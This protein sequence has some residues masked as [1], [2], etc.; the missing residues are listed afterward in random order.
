MEARLVNSCPLA[1]T[2][3]NEGVRTFHNVTDVVR[4]ERYDDKLL[5]IRMNDETKSLQ[6]DF[7]VL[8]T[9]VRP[10]E[11]LRG[12]LTA[13]VSGLARDVSLLRP[14]APSNTAS[15]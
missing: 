14:N 11:H 6:L 7:T 3:K 9:Q 12:S 15:K 5:Q 4:V 13:D 2:L 10:R 8:N 1:F